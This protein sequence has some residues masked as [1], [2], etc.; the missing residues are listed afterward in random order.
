[1]GG[2]FN[3][4]PTACR[5]E[6]CPSEALQLFNQ[7]RKD[8]EWGEKALFNMVEICLNPDSETVGGETFRPLQG[9]GR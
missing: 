2:K 4:V 7:V 8:S 5:Y 6:N 1:M 9:E 3:C